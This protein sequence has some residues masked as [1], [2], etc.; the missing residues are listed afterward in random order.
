MSEL[1]IGGLKVEPMTKAKGSLRVGPYF[2]HNRAHIRRWVLIP[3]TVIR[4][5]KDGPTLC[6]FAGSHPTEYAGIDAA[7]RLTREIK[8][9]DLRGTL[10]VTPVVNT[11]GFYE[12]NY[13]NPIDGKNIQGLYPG[14]ERVSR[15]EAVQSTEISDLMA[16]KVFHEIVM[17]ANYVLDFHG[18]DLHETETWTVNVPCTGSEE[19]DKRSKAMAKASG[20]IYIVCQNHIYAGRAGGLKEEAAKRGKP[21]ILF[22]LG[23]GGLLLPVESQ[24]IFD[25]TLN[26]M[27]HLNMIGGKPTVIKGQPGTTKRQTQ[28]F[29]TLQK[30]IYFTKRGL[31]YT[32]LKAGDSVIKGQKV[33]ELKDLEGEVIETIYAPATG[34]ITLIIP[35]P[36][37]IEGDM[38]IRVRF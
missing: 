3:F 31:Y 14:I 9:E 7:I 13:I 17:K 23:Q 18:G 20:I 24:A 22:E 2:Y 1:E 28:T 5:T 15:G 11:P 33:G 32:F 27:R 8:P 10:V 16:Y 4:G 26:I 6:V 30:D 37:K 29:L 35:N 25:G 36:V 34:I 21:S 19:I 38:A 12:R